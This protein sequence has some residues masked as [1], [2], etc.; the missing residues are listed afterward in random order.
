MAVASDHQRS[1]TR[2]AS[3]IDGPAA[4]ERLLQAVDTSRQGYALFDGSDRLVYC[5]RRYRSLCD[6]FADRLVEGIDFRQICAAAWDS[7]F[8]ADIGQ[9]REGWLEA[10]L[11]HFRVF[12]GPYRVAL[13]DGRWLQV[14]ERPA[15][16]GGVV[17]TVDDMGGWD[18]IDA[19]FQRNGVRL[20]DLLNN[21]PAL[22]YLIDST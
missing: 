17:L 19:L 21:L 20:A 4:R 11:R 2:S 8:Y 15:P 13:A 18:P 7:G 16:D 9:S 10:R 3:G 5:N 6:P 22:V 14:E 1:A 12:D